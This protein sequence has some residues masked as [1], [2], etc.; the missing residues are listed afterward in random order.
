MVPDVNNNGEIATKPVS[1]GVAGSRQGDGSASVCLFWAIVVAV[2]AT[3][4]SSCTVQ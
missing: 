3:L 4:L 2:A 1:E